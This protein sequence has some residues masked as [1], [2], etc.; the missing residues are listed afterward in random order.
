MTQEITPPRLSQDSLARILD[1]TQ[2]LAE[3]FDLVHMLT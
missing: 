2:K 3:P 1:V